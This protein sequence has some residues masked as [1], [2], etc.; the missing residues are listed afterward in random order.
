MH[1]SSFEPTNR[2][3]TH[4]WLRS[5][6]ADGWDWPPGRNRPGGNPHRWLACR[7]TVRWDGTS[8]VGG[9]VL[10]VER[11]SQ[12]VIESRPQPIVRRSPVTSLAI[13]W[14]TG[15][16]MVGIGRL[17]VIDPVATH[18]VGWRAGVRSVWMTLRTVG[19]LVSPVERK[20]ASVVE[21]CAC[22]TLSRRAVTRLT[23]D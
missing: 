12:I 3:R 15:L 1:L 2:G 18:T 9:P 13:G 11:P 21:I 19:R 8:T 23:V 22:P 5:L 10:T 17:I 20:D 14:E 4:S 7:C 6:P 16:W